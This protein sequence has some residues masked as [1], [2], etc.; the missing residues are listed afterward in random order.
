M[1][2]I[3]RYTKKNYTRR[4][5]RPNS[6]KRKFMRYRGKGLELY[7][8]PPSY[9]PIPPPRVPS[10][11]IPPP[12]APSLPKPP[13]PNLPIPPPPKPLFIEPPPN[14]FIFRSSSSP[15]QISQKKPKAKQPKSEPAP[16]PKPKPKLVIEAEPKAKSKLVIEAEPK[17]AP[18]PEPEEEIPKQRR[19]LR[20]VIIN[21]DKNKV[22]KRR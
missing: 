10:L 11:P 17:A 5:K 21:S 6:K 8:R 18:A 19:S 12:R 1:A 22:I 7:H 2:I 13:H 20:Q 4:K 14:Q 3:R 15:R 9:L 16:K